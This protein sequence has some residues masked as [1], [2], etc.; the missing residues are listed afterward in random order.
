MRNVNHVKFRY[1]PTS[2]WQTLKLRIAIMLPGRL[3]VT[4]IYQKKKK[5]EDW[6]VSIIL[7][8]VVEG[9]TGGCFLSNNMKHTYQLG[10]MNGLYASQHTNTWNLR[11][12][13]ILKT[14]LYSISPINPLGT[15]G[16]LTPY[17]IG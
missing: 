2:S 5:S 14:F 1:N 8:N 15:T 16:H 7:S 3:Q 6:C 4:V 11:K 12:D 10:L 17:M 9:A 13:D